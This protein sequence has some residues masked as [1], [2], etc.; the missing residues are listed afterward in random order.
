MTR[1][2]LFAAVLLTTTAPVFAQTMAAPTVL[3]GGQSMF[4][5]GGKRGLTADAQCDAMQASAP[6]I[7]QRPECRTIAVA[8]AQQQDCGVIGST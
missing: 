2:A 3:V 4:P 7:V 5:V 6:T 1:V 8:T